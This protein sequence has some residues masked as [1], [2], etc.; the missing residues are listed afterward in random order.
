[1]QHWIGD[2]AMIKKLLLT[3]ILGILPALTTLSLHADE[4]AVASVVQSVNINTADADTLA[5]ILE[6][7]GYSR[8]EAIIKYREAYGPFIA[9]D[10]L[11]EVKGVGPSIVSNNRDRIT[12]E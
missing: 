1:M 3:L 9:V 4:V 5:Q 11:L 2:P 10:D 7:V 12:L 8:A 6:G